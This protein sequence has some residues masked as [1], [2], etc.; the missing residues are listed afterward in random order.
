MRSLDDL[1][2]FGPVPPFY[3]KGDQDCL[4]PY[5]PAYSAYPLDHKGF[6]MK[7]MIAVSM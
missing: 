4:L 1:F 5:Y 7:G 3:L 2:H 6:G